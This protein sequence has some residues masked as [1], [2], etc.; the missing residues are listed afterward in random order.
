MAAPYGISSMCVSGLL[1]LGAVTNLWCRIFDKS[2]SP[3]LALLRS[4]LV[5]EVVKLADLAMLAEEL[6]EAVF[7][8]AFCQ[9]AYEEAPIRCCHDESLVSCQK[10]RD[11]DAESRWP[12]CRL[13]SCACHE[14][15][16][17]SE[18]HAGA[19]ADIGSMEHSIC[20]CSIQLHR[21]RL[22]C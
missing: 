3:R 17:L 21:A 1:S 4:G 6:D 22:A 12:P 10:Q 2:I 11:D 15:P 20:S 8:Y 19:I 16:H 5:K 9:I 14:P 13:P 18:K 7:V